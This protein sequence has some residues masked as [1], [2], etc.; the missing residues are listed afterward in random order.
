MDLTELYFEIV[1][2]IF[3]VFTGHPGCTASLALNIRATENF[4][5]LPWPYAPSLAAA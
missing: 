2:P 3:P 1:Y 5:P 4:T